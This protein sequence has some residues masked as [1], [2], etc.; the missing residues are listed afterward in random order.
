MNKHNFAEAMVELKVMGTEQ[1]RPVDRRHGA[2]EDLFGVS[3][4]N[5]NKLEQLFKWQISAW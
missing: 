1:N 5:L 2:E 3:F 4:A